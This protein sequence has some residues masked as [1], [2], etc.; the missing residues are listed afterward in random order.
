MWKRM[1]PILIS[2]KV[3]LFSFNL[4]F[5][6]EADLLKRIEK[7]EKE[8]AELKAQLEEERKNNRK[9]IRKIETAVKSSN[10]RWYGNLRT[11]GAL[12]DTDGVSSLFQSMEHTRNLKVKE[13]SE[14]WLT[15][16]RLNGI[17]R[18]NDF[19]F[20]TRISAYY[21]WGDRD[22]MD[23]F[24]YLTAGRVPNGGTELF[25]ERAY[26]DWKFPDSPVVLT[27]GRLPVGGGPPCDF[28]ED[29]VRKSV[30]PALYFDSA[31]DGI[32]LSVGLEG[33]TGIKHSGIRIGYGKPY[34]SDVDPAFYLQ[35]RDI[36]DTRGLFFLYE[37]PLP[38]WVGD[39]TLFVAGVSY[40]WNIPNL[41]DTNG[42]YAVNATTGE[43]IPLNEARYNVGDMEAIGIHLQAKR[44]LYS[45]F[46]T[47]LSA[48]VTRTLPD[49]VY[50]KTPKGTRMVSLLG[51][52][53][54]KTGW[55]FYTGFRYNFDKANKVGFEFNHGSKYWLTF[56]QSPEDLIGKLSVNGNAHETYLI[57]RFTDRIMSRVGFIYLDYDYLMGIPTWA[58]PPWKA[59]FNV[60]TFYG[61]LDFRF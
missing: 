4:T 51:S 2:L 32:I 42:V 58:T 9:R 45:N 33:V 24:P 21:L 56:S 37:S 30:Y 12:V 26:V 43:L 59:D 10:V 22:R 49:P 28:K 31:M 60:K 34:Q 17:A 46:D 16:F 29:T 48:G 19:T 55:A 61:L 3:L 11:I 5:A 6:S 27:V 52:D 23:Y 50:V 40:M 13:K 39:E 54:K 41:L 25:L 36:K 15:R 18:F 7:L 57:H 20:H 1:L 14:R 44:F 8:L 53:E 38:D 35:R 47:F